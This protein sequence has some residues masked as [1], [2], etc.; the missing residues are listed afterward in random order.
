MIEL[1]TVPY[2][3]LVWIVFKAG[4]CCGELLMPWMW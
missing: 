4:Q 1:W 3:F 2:G